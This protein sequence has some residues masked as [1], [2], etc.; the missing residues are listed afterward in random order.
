M[1]ALVL[2]DDPLA[3]VRI[4]GLT[5]RER[6]CRVARRAGAT[7]VFVIAD[8]ASRA[9]IPD[10]DHVLVIR[11]NQLVHTP[12]VAPLAGSD[13]PLAIAVGP[14]DQYAGAIC[15]RGTEAHAIIAALRANTDDTAYVSGRSATRVVHGAIARHAIATAE[16]RRAAHRLLYKI[17][18]KPQDNA[19]TKYLFRPVS[20]QLTRF[21]A[22]TPI[23]PNQIS[24]LVGAFC[25][26]GCWLTAHRDMGMVIAGTATVLFASY[27]DC[28]DGEIARIKLTTSRFGAWID[29]VI[30]EASTIGYM[31]ALGY[32][33]KLYF[34]PQYFGS[35]GFDPW[36]TAALICAALYAWSMYC[37]YYNIIVAVGSANSQDYVGRFDVVPGEQP[38]TVR[39][40]PEVRPERQLPPVLAFAAKYLA[41]MVRRD[42]I[43]WASMIMAITHVTHVSFAIQVLGGVVIAPVVSIDHVRLRLQRRSIARAG[44]TLVAPG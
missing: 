38:N 29:T 9:A 16:D 35:L 17:L 18:V 5:A 40:R 20:L 44:Q 4:A 41:F 21:L 12:L 6:A 43:V 33:C 15:A 34:G 7:A 32:H 10:A 14:D 2:A 19:I 11:A 39:L 3:A 25:I 31:V 22:W 28:C 42:F 24:Y 27:L 26:L 1:L 37:I 23:T 8:A 13:A 36:M 30:D